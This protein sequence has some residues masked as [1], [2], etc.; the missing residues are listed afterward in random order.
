M[1]TI[2][3]WAIESLD[4]V[5]K[6][7]SVHPQTDPKAEAKQLAE[8]M[9]VFHRLGDWNESLALAEAALLLDPNAIELHVYSLKALIPLIRVAH[10]NVR[11][12]K[13]GI[14]RLALVYRRGLDH[15]EPLIRTGEIEKHGGGTGGSLFS[16]FRGSANHLVITGHKTEEFEMQLSVL[17]EEQVDMIIRIYPDIAKRD[18]QMRYFKFALDFLPRERKFKKLGDAILDLAHLPEVVSR[19][20]RLCDSTYFREENA[21][22]LMA[23]IERLSKSSNTD[24]QLV[25]ATLKRRLD[26]IDLSSKQTVKPLPHREIEQMAS[27]KRVAI[28]LDPNPLKTSDVQFHG[29][30]PCTPSVDVFWT[31]RALFLMTEKG[32][33][34]KVWEGVALE[35]P[36]FSSV[37]FDGKYV[38]C[39]VLRHRLPPMLL[40]LNLDNGKVHDVSSTDGLPIAPKNVAATPYARLSLWATPIKPSQAC[41][42]GGASGRNWVAVVT[43]DPA[44]ETGT[45]KVIHEARE[46]SERTDLDQWKNP[47]LAFNPTAMYSV[48]GKPDA[49]GNRSCRVIIHRE[50]YHPLVIDPAKPETGVFADRLW[51]QPSI[52]GPTNLGVYMVEPQLTPD[53]SRQLVR[54]GFPGETKEVVAKGLP[55]I[56]DSLL[57]IHEQQVHIVLIDTVKSAD[58][59]SPLK[60]KYNRVGQWW[61]VDED[62]KNL[63]QVA[64]NL[65]QM[66]AIGKSSHYGLV[67]LVANQTGSGGILHTVEVKE[68]T[69]KE[70]K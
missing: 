61:M 56:G 45:A 9:A 18:V 6:D 23:L 70:D 57:T 30:V 63:R 22:E 19:S 36:H 34:R 4:T 60:I 12:S 31:Y 67:A 25:A 7:K 49:D 11:T 37:H 33:L 27:F 28:S 40:V 29:I 20:M 5:L 35:N 14:D 58:P 65:P 64:T 54:V 59:K 53:R 66:N 62:G 42:T 43:F 47:K 2:K 51:P 32:K 24:I 68:P 69:M 3:R 39:T 17:R 21:T 13:N 52:G 55:N 10:G 16:D 8:R 44:S 1:P 26:R 50:N 15:L 48:H 41:V 38:W 46:I